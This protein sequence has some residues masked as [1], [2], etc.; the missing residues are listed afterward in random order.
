M[1][2]DRVLLHLIAGKGGDGAV[3]F[4]R[5]K[6][7]PKGGPFGGN[8]GN[9]GSVVFR[10]SPH[11]FSLE[12]FR[13]LRT[14]KAPNGKP[15]GSNH[16]TGKTGSNIFLDI[17]LGTLLKDAHTGEVLCDFVSPQEFVACQGG[18]GGKGNSTFKSPTNQTPRESTPG[19]LGE[20]K[21][22]V[23][24][25]KLIADIGLVGLPNAG[26]STLISSLTQTKAR[27]GAYPFTTL[28]PNLGFVELQDG[29]KK[30]IADIPGI[31]RGAH[32]NKGLGL[33][34]LR[35][36]ERTQALL[37]VVDLF[38][39][40][41]VEDF[42]LLRDELS[43]YD[44]HLL[45]KPYL[46]LLNKIDI[47]GGKELAEHF[48]ESYPEEIP[49]LISAKTGA[50]CDALKTYLRGLFFKQAAASC[51]NAAVFSDPEEPTIPLE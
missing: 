26:K 13:N 14:I 15:G 29:T 36:I 11:P 44:P 37:F 19:T 35:H 9:G 10:S 39:P 18:K 24:E 28:Q 23:L 25:L 16:Q 43:S 46:L 31:I 34:F 51:P 4:R 3:A 42:S 38:S 30:C 17:P 49:L 2:V 20:I 6:F 33:A 21:E 50:G 45:E 8:G 12:A 1:F 48:M 22:V 7:L 27:T 5:E 32:K 40:T 41:A 47:P